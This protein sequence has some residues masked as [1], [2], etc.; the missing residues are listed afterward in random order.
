MRIEQICVIFWTKN[1]N[2]PNGIFFSNFFRD[3]SIIA[4][5]IKAFTMRIDA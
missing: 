3:C 5:R 4:M 1:V 2:F